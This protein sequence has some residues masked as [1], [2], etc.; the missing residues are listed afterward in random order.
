MYLSKRHVLCSFLYT[1]TVYV[2]HHAN[3]EDTVL[4]PMF[5]HVW[6]TGLDHSVNK[7]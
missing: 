3:M 5:V 7:V 4:L 1:R 2:P 6:A